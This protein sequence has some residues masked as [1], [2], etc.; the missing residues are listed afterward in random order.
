M[1]PERPLHPDGEVWICSPC[2][3]IGTKEQAEAH[4]AQH[5]HT[6][7]RV[8]DDVAE[9]VRVER[10]RRHDEFVA[11]LMLSARAGALDEEQR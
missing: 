6:I 3:M 4:K 10:L 2:Q 5:G 7:E 11:A 9:A 8:P 1:L